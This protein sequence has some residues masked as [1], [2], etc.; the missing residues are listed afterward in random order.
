MHDIKL[1]TEKHA[2]PLLAISMK[3]EVNKRRYIDE[4]RPK[5]LEPQEELLCNAAR[6]SNLL[7][8]GLQI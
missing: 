2:P 6:G 4:A 5:R 3:S 7:R 1:T 8:E